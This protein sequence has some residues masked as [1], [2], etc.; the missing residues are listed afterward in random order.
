VAG[1]ILTFPHRQAVLSV[2]CSLD[3]KPCLD[4]CVTPAL[5]SPSFQEFHFGNGF[6][7]A[8]PRPDYPQTFLGDYRGILVSDGY[9]AH[10]GWRDQCRMHGPFQATLRRSPQD[11]KEWWRPPE[12]ALRFF[13]Q[14]YRI[15]RQARDESPT[16]VKCRLTAL[17]AFG[18][19][20]ACLS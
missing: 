7:P 1:A 5:A 13:E 10:I 20:T 4:G 9:T 6:V 8:G 15:E 17:T 18:N 3:G 14:L 2:R 11:Q 12:Q 16:S 19:S